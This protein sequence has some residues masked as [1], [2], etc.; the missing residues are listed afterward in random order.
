MR[1]WLLKS[2]PADWS[3]GDQVAKG[4]V[5]EDWTEVRNH[6]A[7]GMMREMAVGDLA[8]FYHSRSDRACVGIVRVIA[9]AHPDPTD[10]TGKWDCVAVAAVEPV[11][12]P[13]PLRAVKAT[14]ELVG[15]ALVRMRACPCSR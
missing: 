12:R 13:V 11:A 6:Q 4:D 7:R 14:P 9:A 15:M 10:A 1:Y 3:W 2:E 5:G 8:L